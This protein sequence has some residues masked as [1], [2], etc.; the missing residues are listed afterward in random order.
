MTR[1]KERYKLAVGL[2]YDHARRDVPVIGAR[3]ECLAA[4]QMVKL[5]HRYGV[6]VIERPALARALADRELDTPIPESLFEVVSAL[7]F[8]LDRCLF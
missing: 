4:D 2:H 1:G 8:E 3:G 5:A 7:L 6:P